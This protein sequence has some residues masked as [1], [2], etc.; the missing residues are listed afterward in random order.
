MSTIAKKINLFN[1]DQEDISKSD[2]C[3][4]YLFIMFIIGT[5]TL[6]IYIEHIKYKDYQNEC[7][8][9]NSNYHCIKLEVYS[10][11]TE[12]CIHKIGSLVGFFLGTKWFFNIISDYVNI[13]CCFI[14]CCSKKNPNSIEITLNRLD[15]KIVNI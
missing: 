2:V 11:L 12:V 14:F 4:T 7:K 9:N 10:I 1:R 6:Y 8:K 13:L 3:L 5:L 15:N